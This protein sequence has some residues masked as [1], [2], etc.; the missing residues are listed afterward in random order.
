MVNKICTE[1]IVLYH[2][3]IAESAL[4]EQILQSQHLAKK[5]HPSY[6][7]LVPSLLTALCADY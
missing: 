3:I 6:N 1:V 2:W 5:I 4:T 7:E